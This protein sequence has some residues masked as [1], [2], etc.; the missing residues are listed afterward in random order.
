MSN[1]PQPKLEIRIIPVTPFQQNCSMIWDR[2]TMDGVF[3]DP[4]GDTDKLM[5][6][7]K[8]LSVNI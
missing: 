5:A 4:G 2:E 8:D 1:Q 7:A 3:I 6:A